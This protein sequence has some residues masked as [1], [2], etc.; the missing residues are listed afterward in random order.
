MKHHL[1][2][3]PRNWD[4]CACLLKLASNDADTWNHRQSRISGIRRLTAILCHSRI[5]ID[6][7][8]KGHFYDHLPQCE[9]THG[10]QPRPYPGES[11]P[12]GPCGHLPIQAQALWAPNGCQHRY[13][14]ENRTQDELSGWI[15]QL[16]WDQNQNLFFLIKKRRKKKER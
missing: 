14:V 4:R 13:S 5:E 16:T 2:K 12:S 6:P 15:P 3:S 10:Y 11:H 1:P 7:A 8:H 9:L